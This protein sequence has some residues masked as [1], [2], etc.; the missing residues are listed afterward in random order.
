MVRG[1]E[2]ERREGEEEIPHCRYFRHTSFYV[3]EFLFHYICSESDVR[4]RR[5]FTYN[6]LSEQLLLVVHSHPLSVPDVCGCALLTIG[7]IDS[8]ACSV[9]NF[10]I[11]L[12]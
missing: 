7:V 9:S 10:S 4:Q 1:R 5:L 2:R 8:V 11:F 6:E 3:Q 12:S